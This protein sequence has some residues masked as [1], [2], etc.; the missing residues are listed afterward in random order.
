MSCSLIDALYAARGSNPKN[1]VEKR[2]ANNTPPFWVFH[3]LF[4]FLVFLV[5]LLFFGFFFNV[6]PPFL[7]LRPGS[8][9]ALDDTIAA[10][11]GSISRRIIG[12][13]GSGP[14]AAGTERL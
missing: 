13:R 7:M 11:I 14:L 4:M 3:F 8:A 1:A 10:T 2:A 5:I 6:L 9:R 12:L